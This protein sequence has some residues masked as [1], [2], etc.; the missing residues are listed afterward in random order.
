VACLAGD[1]TGDGAVT[2]RGDVADRETLRGRDE[3]V[4][5]E[6]DEQQRDDREPAVRIDVFD[7]D[8]RGAEHEGSSLHTH[9]TA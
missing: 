2:E 9:V 6:P 5:V 8:E 1:V 3:R 7:R 4:D